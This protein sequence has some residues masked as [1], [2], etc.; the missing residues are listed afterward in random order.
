[1]PKFDFVS[2]APPSLFAYQ[3]ATK[4]PQKETVEKVA[5]AVLSTTAKATARQKTKEKEK[6]AESM[7]TVCGI[8]KDVKTVKLISFVSGREARVRRIQG[9]GRGRW[10]DA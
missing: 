3:P 7:D 10:D 4:P 6:A 9:Y 5:T 8:F 1:L 2:N